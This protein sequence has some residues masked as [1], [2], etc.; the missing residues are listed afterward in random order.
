MFIVSQTFFVVLHILRYTAPQTRR[1]VKYWCTHV[2]LCTGCSCLDNL[3]NSDYRL[4]TASRGA[5]GWEERA[6]GDLNEAHSGQ[7]GVLIFLE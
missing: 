1:W 2:A 6:D 7:C 5:G 3:L 4:A